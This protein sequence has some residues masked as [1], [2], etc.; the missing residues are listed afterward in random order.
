MLYSHNGILYKEVTV[1]KRTYKHVHILLSGE[2]YRGGYILWFHFYNFIYVYI[3][4]FNVQ[5]YICVLCLSS[6]LSLCLYKR[7][8]VC[9][10]IHRKEMLWF[11]YSL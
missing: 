4:G 6:P 1:Y 3:D 8:H 7:V 5:V 2:I 10:Q 11:E 9:T